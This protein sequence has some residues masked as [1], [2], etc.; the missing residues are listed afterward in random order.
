MSFSSLHCDIWI[1]S[2]QQ[3]PWPSSD[4]PPWKTFE[5]RNCKNME[6]T[7]KIK[8]FEKST[9]FCKYLSN[10]KSWNFF[11][12]VDYYLVSLSLKFHEDSSINARARV[13]NVCMHVL[14]RVRKFT[15]RAR[16]FVNGSSSLKLK[17][18]TLIFNVF[19]IF[20]KFCT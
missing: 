8:V 10:E 2:F 13:V 19:S 3:I 14:S 11:V 15:T 6:N 12:V 17:L 7:L 4:Y 16:T 18:N 20:L 1:S 5:V 9:L